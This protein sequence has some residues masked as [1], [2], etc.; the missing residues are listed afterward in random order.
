MRG[1]VVVMGVVIQVKMEAVG[2]VQVVKGVLNL[3]VVKVEQDLQLVLRETTVVF[4][5]VEQ[6][7]IM[8][9]VVVTA[10]AVAADIT[11][12]VAAVAVK[13]DPLVVEAEVVLPMLIRV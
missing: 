5:K 2:V 12:A 10:A 4:F 3:L 13:V 1:L 6:V 8:D 7:V 11:A 9:L